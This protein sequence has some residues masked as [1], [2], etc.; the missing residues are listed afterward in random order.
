M[1]GTLLAEQELEWQVGR[2]YFSIGSMTKVDALGGG[3]DPRELLAQI[4]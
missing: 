1:V 4:A 3:D 2:R